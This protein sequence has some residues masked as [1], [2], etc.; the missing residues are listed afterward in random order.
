[1]AEEKK[2]EENCH[3]LITSP[4]NKGGVIKNTHY[5]YMEKWSKIF[6]ALFT[7]IDIF[8]QAFLPADYPLPVPF[9]TTSPCICLDRNSRNRKP[10]NVAT[11]FDFPTVK[12]KSYIFMMN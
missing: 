2:K 3:L 1:M 10:E 8:T 11:E 6:K 9:L 5:P 4:L 7:H 12:Q